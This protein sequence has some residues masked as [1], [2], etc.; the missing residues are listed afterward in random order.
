MALTSTIYESLLYDYDTFLKYRN[1]KLP[2]TTFVWGPGNWDFGRLPANISIFD[3]LIEQTRLFSLWLTDIGYTGETI[4]FC[5]AYPQEIMSLAGTAPIT[6]DSPAS[7]IPYTIAYE[8]TRHEPDSKGTQPFSGSGKDAKLNDLGIFEDPDTELRYQLFSRKW[9]SLVTYTCIGRSNYETEWLTRLFEVFCTQIERNFLQA[10]VAKVAPC[11][12]IK[13]ADIQLDGTG[14]QYRKTLM[15]YRTEEFM[16]RGPLLDVITS[17]DIEVNKPDVP[18]AKLTT[19]YTTTE[20]TVLSIDAGDLLTV[21][22]AGVPTKVRL[23]GVVCPE[24]LPNDRAKAE[25][26]EWKV[27]VADVCAKG[28]IARAYTEGVCSVGNTVIVETDTTLHDTAGNMFAYVYFNGNMMLNE[29]LLAQGYGWY[30][31]SL[32]NTRYNK[33]FFDIAQM[34]KPTRTLM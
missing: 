26:A 22:Y 11:G 21:Q 4:L 25:A 19:A 34:R 24:Q 27:L 23:I 5:P 10:G 12:R 30:T 17:I 1:D 16:Y 7:K 32:T 18:E 31:P 33:R 2:A 8:I 28:S 15:W 14:V 13:L 29:T 20:S 6:S 3:F 9:E